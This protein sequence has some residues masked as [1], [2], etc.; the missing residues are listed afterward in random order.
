M[1]EDFAYWNDPSK[2]KGFFDLKVNESIISDSQD[3]EDMP[4]VLLWAKDG[5]WDP[6]TSSF[7]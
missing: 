2:N 1:T 3:F 4:F 7:K 5:I 6:N